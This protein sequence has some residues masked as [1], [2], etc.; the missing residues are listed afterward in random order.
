[1]FELQTLKFK[2]LSNPVFLELKIQTQFFN[3]KTYL[4]FATLSLANIQNSNFSI[5]NFRLITSLN[6]IK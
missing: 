3:W 6:F 1:M 4:T 5:L 2:Q